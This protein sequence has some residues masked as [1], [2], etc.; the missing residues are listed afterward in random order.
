MTDG[1]IGDMSS[2]VG[3]NFESYLL[4]CPVQDGL[5]IVEGSIGSNNTTPSF[6]SPLLFEKNDQQAFNQTTHNSSNNLR[7]LTPILEDTFPALD[8]DAFQLNKNDIGF[9][10]TD[11][12]LQVHDNL[13]GFPAIP[14]D[15]M[16]FMPDL[17]H[18]L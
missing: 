4:G 13:F 11:D 10:E 18:M 5:A 12:T 3:E 7:E 15:S 14:N 8:S 16:V 1:G 17:E 9:F 2:M 6:Q